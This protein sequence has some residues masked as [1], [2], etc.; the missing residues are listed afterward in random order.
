MS[1]YKYGIKNFVIADI[2][3]A[4]G[5]AVVAG[6]LDIVD[7]IYRDTF[8]MTEEDGT[9]TDLYS[10]MDNTPKLSFQEPGKETLSLEL[11][12]TTPARLAFFLGGNVV[13]SGGK[14]TWSKPAN[15]GANEKHITITLIDDTEMVIP[16]AKIVGKKNFQFRRNNIWTLDVNITPL[17]PEHVGLAA[18]DISEP[19][20]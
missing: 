13:S 3:P 10:E 8:D 12:D 19:T 9:S 11:M 18:I 4:N 14:D 7:D 17:T 1:K 2:D 6:S 5:N 20:A 16:R 15:Q